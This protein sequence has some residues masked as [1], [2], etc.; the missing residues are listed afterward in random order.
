MAIPDPTTTEWVPLWDTE[1]SGG[2]GAPHDLLSTEHPDTTPATVVN[3]ALIVGK[4]GTWQREDGG[5]PGQV[6]IT[7]PDGTLGWSNDGSGLTN[8]P[9]AAHDLLS[10]PHPDTVP[11]APQVGD[12]VYAEP[13]I[14]EGLDEV[15]FDGAW[16]AGVPIGNPFGLSYW[17][18]GAP[19]AAAYGDAATVKWV[20]KPLADLLGA[21]ASETVGV[22]VYRSSNLILSDQTLTAV[23]WQMASVDDAA[24]WN[25][26]SPT[27]LTVPAGRGG[28][29][30]ITAFATW[31]DA[32]AGRGWTI[33]YVNGAE[34]ARVLA[35][36]VPNTVSPR[37]ANAQI[38]LNRK[39]AVGD[40]VEFYLYQHNFAPFTIVGGATN[41]FL[42]M[43][44]A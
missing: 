39:L 25:G 20:R 23:P 12:V 35:L 6:L 10:A 24:F 3:G 34:V 44:K 4:A 37:L 43:V 21:S 33:L 27:R 1:G 41:T 16:I 30:S 2:G 42:S 38:V 18:E 8:V 32:F 5:D 9:V 11:A 13:G 28:W 17:Y 36:V 40:Y 31:T 15:F 14:E 22:T 19:F 29:Y 26:G 7:N